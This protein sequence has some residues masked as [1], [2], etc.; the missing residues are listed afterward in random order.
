M[1]HAAP[2]HNEDRGTSGSSPSPLH[3]SAGPSVGPA[4]MGEEQE[5]SYTCRRCRTELFT[6]EHLEPHAAGAQAITRRR[7]A[8]V[9]GVLNRL[10]G[11]LTVHVTSLPP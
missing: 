9:G 5:A 7:K 6:H 4:G 11:G 10:A 2:S 8:S 3:P 1:T